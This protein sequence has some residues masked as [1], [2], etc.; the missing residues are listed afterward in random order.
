MKTLFSLSLASLILASTQASAVCISIFNTCNDSVTADTDVIAE[1]PFTINAKNGCQ[2]ANI[3]P[4][5]TA[6]G[7]APLSYTLTD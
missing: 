6:V 3:S 5:I 7:A 1:G 4:T 2:Q